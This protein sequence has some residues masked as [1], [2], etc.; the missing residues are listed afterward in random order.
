ML[1]APHLK[2]Q[3][4]LLVKYHLNWII[5]VMSLTVVVIVE[6]VFL[7]IAAIEMRQSLQFVSQNGKGKLH[8]GN[9]E[10]PDLSEV[11]TSDLSDLSS[12]LSYDDTSS[13]I[14]SINTNTLVNLEANLHD[15]FLQSFNV[16]SNMKVNQTTFKY[17]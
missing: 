6:L 3:I 12:I 4:L 10:T 8:V 11:N 14:D 16:I 17:L 1:M 9:V 15:S 5:L 13:S 2:L 7:A